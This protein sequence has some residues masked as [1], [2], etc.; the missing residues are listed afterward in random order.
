MTLEFSSDHL[1]R[2]AP[3]SGV[4]P[5]MVDQREHALA[6][7][8]THGAIDCMHMEKPRPR[9]STV[10][11]RMRKHACFPTRTPHSL[12]TRCS[13]VNSVRPESGTKLK[14]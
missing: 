9:V 8:A 11:A 3:S 7:L 2:Q 4:S 5:R 12:P 6:L 1:R 14:K 10:C 13:N